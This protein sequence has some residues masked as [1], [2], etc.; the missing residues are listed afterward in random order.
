M[1]LLE[2]FLRH[3]EILVAEALLFLGEWKIITILQVSIYGLFIRT[4]LPAFLF[5]PYPN[6]VFNVRSVIFSGVGIVFF[7]A[8]RLGAASRVPVFGLC[9][10]RFILDWILLIIIGSVVG[11]V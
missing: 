5:G 2:R 11:C 7:W 4:I 6:R 9:N 3:D 8:T 10:R 1:L